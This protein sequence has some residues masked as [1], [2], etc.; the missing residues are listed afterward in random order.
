MATEK[1]PIL[2][3]TTDK[4]SACMKID[5]QE[6]GIIGHVDFNLTEQAQL[7]ALGEALSAAQDLTTEEG[8]ADHVSKVDQILNMVCPDISPETMKTLI[9]SKKVQILNAYNALG[10]ED[11][12]K[13][14]TDTVTEVQ[15]ETKSP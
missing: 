1:K 12:K 3:L 5:D 14:D 6:Y 11:E 15:P 13:T 8:L 10:A 9:Y 4:F 2:E 7:K